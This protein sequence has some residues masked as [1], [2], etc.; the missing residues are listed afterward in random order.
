MRRNAMRD[1]W[2]DAL[3]TAAIDRELPFLGICRGL[4]VLNV[5]R[6]G[7]LLQHLPDVVGDD[8][9]N[10]GGGRFAANEVEVDAGTEL[11]ELLGGDRE[12]DVK[13]YHHQAVDELG[14]GPARHGALR[15]RH[16][17]GR[18]ARRR[19]RSASPC[20]GTPR[21]TPPRTRGSSRASSPPPATHR[22]RR[23][24]E[25]AASTTLINPADETVMQDVEHTT[26]EEVDEAVARAVVG[27]AGVGG[28]RPRRPRR[29]AP[30]LRRRRRRRTS[31][32]SRSSRCATP[33]IRSARRAGRPGTSA[34]CSTTTRARPSA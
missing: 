20:S 18:R 19:R 2:E 7:T 25:L 4:Q 22:E 23:A 3:L 32:S 33:D 31:R 14:D 15:R 6:G 5:N 29:R 28:P 21:R 11:V 8:R 9:Y 1:A 24:H 27:A 13:S 10:A 16:H 17:P 26:L 34:T 12:L 30:P